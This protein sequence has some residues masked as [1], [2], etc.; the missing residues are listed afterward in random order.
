MLPCNFYTP[1]NLKKVVEKSTL[2]LHIISM[3]EQETSVIKVDSVKSKALELINPF[4][5]ALTIT[6]DK[7][8]TIH[9]DNFGCIGCGKSLDEAMSSFMKDVEYQFKE[10][11]Y[12]G[13]INNEQ[14]AYYDNLNRHFKLIS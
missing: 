7:L 1:E 4:C 13:P 9:Q 6:K 12:Y 8:F 5:A 14:R 2:P 10:I 11:D 3:E